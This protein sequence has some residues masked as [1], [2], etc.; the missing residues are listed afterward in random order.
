MAQDTLAVLR[1]RAEEFPES[2]ARTPFELNEARKRKLLS[3]ALRRVAGEDVE[4][5]VEADRASEAAAAAVERAREEAVVEAE[6]EE[7]PGS[8]RRSLGATATAA[9]GAG[10]W[11]R[12]HAAVHR[13]PEA[14]RLRGASVEDGDERSPRE[15][16]LEQLHVDMDVAPSRPGG[17]EVDAVPLE[18]EQ[19]EAAATLTAKMAALNIYERVSAA[20]QQRA[21]QERAA[22]RAVYDTND[23]IGSAVG[24]V[25]SELDLY[26]LTRV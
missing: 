14:E 25:L 2:E 11:R 1:Q 21:E 24:S 22:H 9:V 7:D 5:E 4:G 17:L 13:R 10:R 20:A 19:R 16:E 23:F 3:R 26:G 8:S 18:V 15:L 12:A 6:Q